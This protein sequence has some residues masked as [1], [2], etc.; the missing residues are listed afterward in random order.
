M[1]EA[2]SKSPRRQTGIKKILILRW[3]GIGDFLLTLPAISAV[4]RHLYH[5]HLAIMGSDDAIELAAT[6]EYADE[7]LPFDWDITSRQHKAKEAA[8][9]RLMQK[10][11]EFDFIINYHSFG[12]IDELL[13]DCGVNYASF[14]EQVFF[15]ERKHASEHFS[16]FVRSIGASSIFSR[17]KVYLSAD[18]EQFSRNFLTDH[19][20]DLRKDCIVAVHVGSGDPRKRWF[21]DRYQQVIHRLV[22]SGAKVLLLLGPHDDDI[23]RLVY[24]GGE[25]D[26]VII[27]HDIPI[28]SVA[29]ILKRA[30]LFLG[31]DS[32]LMHL[33]AAVGIPIV[34]LF[35]PSDPVTW[36]PL[37]PRHVILLGNCP[38]TDLD[39][40]VC[41]SCAFQECLDSI[42]TEEVIRVVRE[43]LRYLR[44]FFSGTCLGHHLPFHPE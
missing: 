22:G 23:V 42:K 18:E 27:V 4:R 10:M 8:R 15:R 21:P 44:S 41:K 19:G 26:N 33:A 7:V 39:G 35:G 17:P 38:I 5:A 2:Q 3:G 28:R 32:G 11:R 12:P 13:D 34:S 14:D 36:G 30:T 40:D 25:W 1:T 20:V 37:G 9:Q 6:R 43:R 31:N 29:A 24:E 16:D